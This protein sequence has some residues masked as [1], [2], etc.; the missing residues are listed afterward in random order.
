M[1]LQCNIKAKGEVYQQGKREE[2]IR[3]QQRRASYR[4][5]LAASG[6]N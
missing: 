4:D 1:L 6:D 3:K 2:S 5:E